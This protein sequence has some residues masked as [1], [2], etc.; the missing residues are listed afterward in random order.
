MSKYRKYSSKRWITPIPPDIRKKYT[1]MSHDELIA[2]QKVLKNET[3]ELALATKKR[4]KEDSHIIEKFNKYQGLIRDKI[5]RKLEAEFPQVK[6][7][8]MGYVTGSYKEN[9]KAREQLISHLTYLVFDPISLHKKTHDEYLPYQANQFNKY[10][11]N[12]DIDMKAE[13]VT[14]DEVRKKTI[15]AWC[16]GYANKIFKE[17]YFASKTEIDIFYKIKKIY[18]EILHKETVNKNKLG[19]NRSLLNAYPELL[20]KS[21]QRKKNARL[22]MFD[23]QSR[24]SGSD[25]TRF[26]KQKSPDPYICPYC[27][28]STKIKNSHVD[29]INPISNGGLSV[30]NNMVLVCS[31]CNL[32]K[33]DISLF[34]F[35]SEKNFNFAKVSQRLVDLGKWV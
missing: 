19:I 15:Y 2:Q 8:V 27:N 29:H 34:R 31:T 17:T 13:K 11:K 6:K 1:L 33:K 20:K 32:S 25:I 12:N 5:K 22:A 26:I 9:N 3:K 7:N 16:G 24:V 23:K 14:Y 18:S 21:K 35:C 30:K 4:S 10:L 28:K